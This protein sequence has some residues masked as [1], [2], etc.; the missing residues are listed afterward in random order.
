MSVASCLLL[1]SL[2]VAALG[3]R[4][5]TRMTHAGIAPRLGVAAWLAAIGSVALS[6]VIAALFL[7]AELLGDWNQP[8]RTVIGV[9][10]DALGAVATGRAGLVLQLGLLLL[11]GLAGGAVAM[12]IWRLA[13]SLV[14][15][16]ARTFEHARMARLAGRQV[17][18][19]DAVVLDASERVAYCVAGRPHT[20][21]VT[22][23]ALDALDQRHLDAVLCHERA[24]LAGRH[25]LILAALRGLAAILPRV[26]LFTT[27][28]AEVSRLLEMCAD[29]AAARSHGS[30][31]VL[32]A[33]LALSGA[34]SIPSGALGATGIGVL[35]RAERLA[36]P[37]RLADR[38]RARLLL[39]VVAAVIAI[40]P[41][42]TGL[43][44]AT[45]LAFCGPMAS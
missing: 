27:G 30:R 2:V 1:Y 28:V 16:R 8:G 35:A 17:D 38:I 14:R 15:A 42:V 18:G 32:R 20:I 26:E 12:L 10:F 19:L 24:H 6:W 44:A 37:A 41:V 5:L 36:A 29:D 40:G 13:R 34:A 45:G 7:L 23:A 31:T 11:A 22:T 3:P 4:L 25:H 9:C 21:V 33:L 39:G 43:L